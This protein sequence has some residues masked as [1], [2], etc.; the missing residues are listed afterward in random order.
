VSPTDFE[1]A[2]NCVNPSTS[3]SSPSLHKTDPEASSLGAPPPLDNKPACP[4]PAESTT[5]QMAALK[6]LHAAILDAIA[7]RLEKVHEKRLARGAQQ[8]PCRDLSV[9]RTRELAAAFHHTM[10]NHWNAGFM[11]NLSGFL[12]R[13]ASGTLH[14]DE[15]YDLVYNA[16][17]FRWEYMALS[18]RIVTELKL[19]RPGGKSCA[20]W[21]Q[22][23]W[24]VS[25]V[26]LHNTT[27]DYWRHLR[28]ANCILKPHSFQKAIPFYVPVQ[29]LAAAL[30]EASDI[31]PSDEDGRIMVQEIA[32]IIL[33][34]EG[35][36]RRQCLSSTGPDNKSGQSPQSSLPA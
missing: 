19:P 35:G 12:G 11:L 20:M 27:R 33:A 15:H 3:N 31:S 32:K 34:E 22:Q 2:D 5:L 7:L 13:A 6:S 9:Q 23:Q 30:T 26:A 14:D 8:H 36:L 16:T 4:Q 24:N 10:T 18:D 25:H 29:Y 21:D 28:D 17:L 1:D